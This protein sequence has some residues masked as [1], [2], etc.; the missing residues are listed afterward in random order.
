MSH[1][2]LKFSGDY[3]TNF[4]N[5][6]LETMAK[7]VRHTRHKPLAPNN[8]TIDKPPIPTHNPFF[9]PPFPKQGQQL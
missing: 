7:L 6:T 1:V 8:N 9:I 3:R 4:G 5:R 2:N